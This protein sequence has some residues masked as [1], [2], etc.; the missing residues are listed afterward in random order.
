MAEPSNPEPSPQKHPEALR[1]HVPL[2]Q[3]NEPIP[4]YCGRIEATQNGQ[5]LNVDARIDLAWLPSPELRLEVPALPRGPFPQLEGLAFRLNDGTAIENAFVTGTNMASGP[6]GASARFSGVVAERVTRPADAPATEARFLLP[7][8][9]APMG[10]P[11]I[12]PSGSNRASRLVLRGGGWVVT[13]DG[14]DNQKSVLEYLKDHSGFGVT[15]VGRLQKEDGKPFTAKEALAT[16]DA[17]AWYVSF[18]TARWTG[19]CLPTGY[20]ADGTQVWQVW[21]YARTVPF[22]DRHSWLCRNQ[23]EQF[24]IPFTA[25]MRL[26]ADKDWE[27]VVRVA[28]HWY[29]EANAQAGSIEGST[30]LTQTAFELLASAVLVERFTWISTEGYEKLTAADR[31]RL[32]FRWAGIPTVLPAELAD[33]LQQAK[34]D[35]WADSATAM[36]MIRN[37]ITHP[38]KK[39]RERFGNHLEGRERMPG[40]SAFGTS[41]SACFGCS[42]IGEP[43]AIAFGAD[44]LGR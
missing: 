44:G 1:P 31:L 40:R 29:V 4:L 14:A 8:F 37:T 3:P 36:T 5:T 21:S 2:L 10:H 35:N 30:I 24:E 42:S 19:P 27:E 43:T 33:L 34:A 12:Y 18:S 28:I 38:T 22:V 17:L 9:I 41:N 13:L 23:G 11:I 16:L 20:D 15:Q 7:N 26:W 39:N 25:F 6:G 32:L